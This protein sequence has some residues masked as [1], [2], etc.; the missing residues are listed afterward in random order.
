MSIPTHNFPDIKLF[1]KRANLSA[2]GGFHVSAF[3]LN[4]S[5]YYETFRFDRFTTAHGSRLTAHGS[6]LT[7]HGSRLTAH[8][9]SSLLSIALL[10][11]FAYSSISLAQSVA[12]KA[13]G[14]TFH[15]SGDTNTNVLSNGKSSDKTLDDED[16]CEALTANLV[17]IPNPCGNPKTD[18]KDATQDAPPP[19]CCGQFIVSNPCTLPVCEVTIYIEYGLTPPTCCVVNPPGWTYT[20]EGPSGNYSDVLSFENTSNNC[21]GAIGATPI[22]FDVCGFQE[23]LIKY[24]VMVTYCNVNKLTGACVPSNT[25]CFGQFISEIECTPAEVGSLSVSQT[26]SVEPGYPNPASSS[27]QFNYLAPNPGMLTLSIFDMLG[28]T[29]STTN[30]VVSQGTGNV[31]LGLSE[32]LAGNYYCVFA[33]N[34]ET[35]TKRLEVK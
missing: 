22:A 20:D 15:F 34:G 9:L 23:A 29:V 24:N 11:C 26:L 18:K 8:G 32:A 19:C 5:N 31:T 4:S 17:P 21:D 1:F 10:L 7:A 12:Q 35:V 30:R 33:L 16:C 6:R 27:I 13:P 25:T 3:S 2:Y 14:I 28:K